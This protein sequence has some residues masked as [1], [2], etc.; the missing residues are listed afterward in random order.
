M[1]AYI[2]A[3]IKIEFEERNLFIEASSGS[4]GV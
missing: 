1:Y 2:V 3:K 4:I